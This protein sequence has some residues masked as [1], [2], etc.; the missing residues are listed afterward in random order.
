MS[1]TTAANYALLN[2]PHF[3]IKDKRIYK[4]LQQVWS[5]ATHSDHSWWGARSDQ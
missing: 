1:K 3:Q 5:R 2:W 4:R